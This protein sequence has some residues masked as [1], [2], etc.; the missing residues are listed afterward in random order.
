[1]EDIR[2]EIK[3]LASLKSE[4][5]TEYYTSFVKQTS[6]WIIMEYCDAGSCLDQVF[7]FNRVEK[8]LFI[9][10]KRY[11]LY[12]ATSLVWIRVFAPFG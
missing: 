6:L 10:G 9:H 4:W 3:I 11:K 5:V 7:L 8:W 1:M 12:H 2:Q